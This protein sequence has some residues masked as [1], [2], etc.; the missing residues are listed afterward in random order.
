MDRGAWRATVRSKE[1]DVTERMNTQNMNTQNK[2]K[3]SSVCLCEERTL[4][5]CGKETCR[6]GPHA[7]ALC[8]AGSPL[9]SA[10]V[11]M[12]PWRCLLVA[13]FPS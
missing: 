12:A 4:A 10:C 6:S 3:C 9:L 1:L 5:E 8:P 7:G 2:S 11:S 13:V